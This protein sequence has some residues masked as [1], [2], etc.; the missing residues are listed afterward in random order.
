MLKE[1]K[2]CPFCGFKSPKIELS[3]FSVVG[4]GKT[5][6]VTCERCN[7]KSGSFFNRQTAIESW[8]RRTITPDTV[9]K[10]SQE[11]QDAGFEDASKWL[12]C[13]YE[14]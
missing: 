12:D 9:N 10:I 14:L 7:G 5:Y 2:P 3:R 8:N 4:L 11:L 13:K 1:L 6:T